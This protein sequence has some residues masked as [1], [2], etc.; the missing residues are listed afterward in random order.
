MKL[1]VLNNEDLMRLSSN[2]EFDIDKLDICGISDLKNALKNINLSFVLEGINRAQSTLLCELGAS[3]CQQSQRYVDM[4]SKDSLPIYTPTNVPMPPENLQKDI[5][6]LFKK[7]LDLYNRMTELKDDSSKNKRKTHTDFKYGISYEDARYVLPLATTTNITITMSGD[8]LVDMLYMIYTNRSILNDL[9]LELS[10]VI[11]NNLFNTI[12]NVIHRNTWMIYDVYTDTNQIST[13][14]ECPHHTYLSK[15][16]TYNNVI[17]ISMSGLSDVT[18]ATLT[19]Q[20]DKSPVDVFDR[21][22]YINEDIYTKSIDL[23]DRVTGYGHT[24]ILEHY[25]NTFAME[26]SLSAYH[27]IIRH[28]LHNINRMNI[29]ELLD[30]KALRFYVP[31]SIGESKFK[32]EYI[33]LMKQYKLLIAQYHDDIKNKKQLM[34]ALP[35]SA[36]IKFIVSSNARNDAIIFRDRLCLTAQTEIRELYDK[37][38]SILY[39][40]CPHIYKHALP[41]CVYN[42][43][44]K[45]GKLSCGDA[46]YMQD[47]YSYVKE[48]LNKK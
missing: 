1:T 33:N 27:Q 25:R 40:K 23:I 14:V 16:S 29:S 26:C 28:R 47:K 43:K 39:E 15:L 37:K 13:K 24:A 31:K 7:S 18:I 10:K 38:F 30:P 19:S 9:Q 41:P 6:N 44:C 48:L 3:Y 11:P 5:E 35:N 45:E 42:G 17:P 32:D 12:W 8:K 46:K 20:N 4:G 2:I 22:E 34:V 36:I 21:W